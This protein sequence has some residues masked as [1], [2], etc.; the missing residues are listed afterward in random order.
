MVYL[1]FFKI[2]PQKINIMIAEDH[3]SVRQGY[4]ALLKEHENFSIT[5][6]ASNGIE[7]LNCCVKTRQT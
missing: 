6:D 7:L 3:L 1:L 5:G 2:M 4:I